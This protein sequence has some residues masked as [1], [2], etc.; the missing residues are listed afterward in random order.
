[1]KKFL[2]PIALLAGAVSANAQVYFEDDF[3]WLKPWTEYHHLGD[4]VGTNNP[5]ATGISIRESAMIGT[6]GGNIFHEKW[7]ATINLAEERQYVVYDGK[8]EN[9]G[10]LTRIFGGGNANYYVFMA[11]DGYLRIGS[12]GYNA[13]LRTRNASIT[14]DPT[15]LYL[16]FDW[17]PCKNEDGTWHDV[18]L[19]VEYRPGNLTVADGIVYG[20]DIE[21][22]T[23]PLAWKHECI[24]LF[25]T[26]GL[27][28]GP[29][30]DK[31]GQGCNVVI[32]I[33]KSS[34]LQQAGCNNFYLDN[35]RLASAK[36]PSGIKDVV[37]E[38]DRT[39][40]VEYFNL[41]G[42]RVN[43]PENGIFIRRQGKKV[44]KVAL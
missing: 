40:P 2:L 8:Y 13:G 14:D 27:S 18:E 19:D 44:S 29:A 21:D 37:V 41:Q 38:N 42:V 31:A 22:K 10:Y 17:C 5:D 15:E 23:K 3:E 1:M 12:Q 39:M 16:E 28:T 30:S 7:D 33:S 24:D 43:N 25:D 9:S 4:P 36:L 34:A 20:V 32:E 26:D 35:I 11:H 6:K